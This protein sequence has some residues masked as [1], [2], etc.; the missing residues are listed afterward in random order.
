MIGIYKIENKINGHCY[1]GQSK[2]IQ[3]RWKDEI[4][5]SKN[6]FD[7]S[8]N[9]PLSKAFRKY[10]IENFS[11]QV[12]EECSINE[13]NEKEKYWIKK[14]NSY[15]N[16][17]NQTLGGDCVIHMA[18]L[19]PEDVEEIQELLSNDVDGIISHKVLAN[20]YNVSTDT[21]QNI[22]AGRQWYNEKYNYPLHIS[23]FDSRRKKKNYCIDCGIEI[24]KNS[25]R[26]NSCEGIRRSSNKKLVTRE[27][28]KQLIRSTPFTKIGERYGVSDNAI[29]K[30][31]KN[32]NLPSKRRDISSYTDE[33]WEML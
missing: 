16:G 5:A 9:Y 26:C 23:Q 11:F 6:S 14:Y 33:E 20:K 1:I 12:I 2:N 18:K 32:Y 30:W 7:S 8:Y 25:T 17:Y 22:N 27:E 15:N 19:I 10:G 21:I 4:N 29:R 31:C 13:L 28:L 3:K 24:F